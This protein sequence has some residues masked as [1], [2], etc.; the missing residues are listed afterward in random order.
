MNCEGWA[1][2]P[3]FSLTPFFGLRPG[4]LS[5]PA[6]TAYR[7]RFAGS[8][9]HPP[10]F[11]RG[12]TGCGEGGRQGIPGNEKADEWTRLEADEPDSHGAEWLQ[13]ADRYG[14]RPMT[15]PRSLA[16]LKREISEKK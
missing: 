7:R 1:A 2:A 15:L 11:C 6:T 16:H 8:Y 9:S 4:W 12:D 10:H 3:R 13:Y 14:G 5:T